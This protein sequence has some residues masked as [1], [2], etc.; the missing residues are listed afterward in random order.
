MTVK[1]LKNKLDKLIKEGNGDCPVTILK[2]GEREVEIIEV[3]N[4][5]VYHTMFKGQKKGRTVLLMD[6]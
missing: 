6:R 4:N 5:V 1:E 3:D 2:E